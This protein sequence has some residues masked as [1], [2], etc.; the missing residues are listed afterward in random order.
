MTKKRDK[1]PNYRAKQCNLCRYHRGAKECRQYETSSRMTKRAAK[2]RCPI[3]GNNK[4]EKSSKCKNYYCLYA[5]C[6]RWVRSS[7]GEF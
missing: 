4:G 2:R 1:C 7:Y 3:C 6:R 5:M